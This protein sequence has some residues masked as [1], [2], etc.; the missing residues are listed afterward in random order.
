MNNFKEN[1]K[2]ANDDIF[3]DKTILQRPKKHIGIKPYLASVVAAAICITAVG[4]LPGIVGDDMPEQN[5]DV[6]PAAYEFP[7]KNARNVP[8]H[9]NTLKCVAI[10]GESLTAEDAEGNIITYKIT[11]ETAVLNVFSESVN[12]SE[13]AEGDFLI[14]DADEKNIAIKIS[15]TE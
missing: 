2:K 3:G 14:V 9:E 12:V 7:G 4:I 1:Y 5:H 10:S 15:I 13:I 8:V 11:T 6:A